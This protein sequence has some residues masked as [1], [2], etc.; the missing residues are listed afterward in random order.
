L[1]RWAA[2]SNGTLAPTVV[3][4]VAFTEDAALVHVS[5]EAE[6][7][8]HEATWQRVI[9]YRLNRSHINEISIFEQDLQK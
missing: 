2:A 7:D 6:V 5:M 1:T 8:G 9:L 3:N 4:T